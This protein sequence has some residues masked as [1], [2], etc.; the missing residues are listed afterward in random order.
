M[1]SVPRR[2]LPPPLPA[3][4][5]ALLGLVAG[6]ALAREPME[7]VVVSADGRGFA[8]ET[9]GEPFR[10]WGF[11]YD[12]DDAGRLIEDYWR[13][14]WPVVEGDFAEMKALGANVVRVHL[15][16]ARFMNAP[17][18]ADEASLA[19]LA[20]LFALAERL[21]LRIVAT[22]LGCYRK[23]DVPAW[24]DAL[25][26]AARWRA[27]A[28]FW[29]AVARVARDSP[30]LLFHDLMNEPVVAGDGGRADWL[31]EPF[32]G[33]H[34]VQFV[35]LDAKGRPRPEIA[36]EWTRALVGAI[37][38]VDP[39]AL[40]SVGLVDWSL[41][42]PGLTSGFVPS[43]VAPELD[44]LCVH[45]YPERGK[46]D[47]A[48][49][50]LRDFAAEGKPVVVEET[51]PLKCGIGEFAEFFDAARPHAAGWIGFYWGRPLEELRA[52]R[53]PTIPEAML[54]Q[55][56]EFFAGRSAEFAAER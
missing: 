2:A 34:Y 39:R 44:L 53:R 41:D 52:L 9:S 5:A 27:Q 13:D 25:D 28:E 21:G 47:E 26:E 18:R 10:P 29:R 7:R 1:R 46:I 55:W 22:G 37:R 24:Y 11:N 38:E 45:L 31:G 40:V 32:G 49:G 54:R 42:R 48:I 51:F 17:D 12:R 35:T 6:A 8:L 16:F 20:D 14:E 19:R 15:Q 50:I 23:A 36:R 30:A 56:L 3:L 33:K 4:F 43:V